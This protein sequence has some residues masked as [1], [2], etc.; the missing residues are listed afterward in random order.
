[1]FPHFSDLLQ[2]SQNQ[3]YGWT[4]IAVDENSEILTVG[5]PKVLKSTLAKCV[6][7]LVGEDLVESFLDETILQSRTGNA[8][9][10]MIS[11]LESKG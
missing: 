5:F 8:I 11:L 2:S 1:M 10:V 6:T 9:R 4:Q 3:N 7:D